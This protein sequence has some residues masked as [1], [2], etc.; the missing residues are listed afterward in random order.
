MLQRLLAHAKG[1]YDDL[2]VVHDGPESPSP[3]KAL[4]AQKGDCWTPEALSLHAPAVPP[5]EMARDYAQLDPNS[6]LSRGYRLKRGRAL[7]GSIHALIDSY[8]GRFF[9]GP[10][11]F[12]QE[13]HWPFA[14]RMARHDWILRLDADEFPSPE[15]ADWLRGFRKNNIRFPKATAFT[16]FWPLW[17]G[18]KSCTEKWPDG[19]LFLFKK[20]RARFWGVAEQVPLPD[21]RPVPVHSKL[22]HAPQRKSFGVRNILFRKQAYAWRKVLADSVTG[23]PSRVPRWRT[24]KRGWPE[25]WKTKIHHPFWRAWVCLLWFPICQAKDLWKN[26]GKINLSACLNPGL[27]HFLIQLAIARRSRT[28]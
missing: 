7:A 12:Q 15:L 22:I 28:F 9:E 6:S 24:G 1:C 2:V 18:R 21:L 27:H 8:G 3:N 19:R 5:P 26:E 25:P 10:R 4:T 23:S 17:D 11:C 16:C 14:W 13:P 20:S